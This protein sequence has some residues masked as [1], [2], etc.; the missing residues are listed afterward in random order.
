MKDKP[1]KTVCESC[2]NQEDSEPDF[3]PNCGTEDP[4]TVE[5][6]YD[7]ENVDFPVIVSW[8]M[9]HDNYEMWRQFC[10]EAFG[11]DVNSNDVANI[12]SKFPRMKYMCPMLYFKVTKSTIEGP[13]LSESEAKDA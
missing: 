3:C 6:L 10:Y 5:Y 9:Y 2:G 12:P 7:M 8:E 4:W 13:F 1:T 11:V